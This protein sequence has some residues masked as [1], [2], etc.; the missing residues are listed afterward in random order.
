[1]EEVTENSPQPNQNGQ[2]IQPNIMNPNLVMAVRPDASNY[3]QVYSNTLENIKCEDPDSKIENLVQKTGDSAFCCCFGAAQQFN[4]PYGYNGVILR[5]GRFNRIVNQGYH[6]INPLTESYK[7]INTQFTTVPL[8]RQ[9][10][11]TKDCISLFISSYASYSITDIETAFKKLGK[12]YDQMVKCMA[13]GALKNVVGDYT[14]DELLQDSQMLGA[15]VYA[16]IKDK[17]SDFGIEISVVEIQNIELPAKLQKMMD[18]IIETQQETQAT[19]YDAQADLDTC[20]TLRK[21]ADELSKNIVSIELQYYDLLKH[22]T[23][24]GQSTIVVPDS[25]L[26]MDRAKIRSD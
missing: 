10:I 18:M 4:I 1:M 11:L 13:K 20:V 16:M 19:Y 6:T 22:M 17:L 21:S 14:M 25:V 7:S 23:K 15:R 24:Y 26:G 5:F 12:D 3:L 8:G 9:K 2:M